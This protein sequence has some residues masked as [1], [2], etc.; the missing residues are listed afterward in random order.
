MSNKG[1]FIKLTVLPC[2]HDGELRYTTVFPSVLEY[3]LDQD[4]LPVLQEAVEGYIDHM[5]WVPELNE[6][7]IDMWINDE[8]KLENKSPCLIFKNARTGELIDVVVGNIVI[9]RF[10]TE[11]ETLSLTDDDIE[12]VFKWLSGLEIAVIGNGEDLRH[13][14]FAYNLITDQD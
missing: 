7:Y 1:K 6:R 11:G 2:E 4:T 8:G 10:N 3:D 9:S 13:C 12:F 14:C 5:S